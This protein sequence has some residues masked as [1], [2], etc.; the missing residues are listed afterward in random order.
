MNDQFDDDLFEDDMLED[1]AVEGYCVRCRESVEI[2]N[3]LPVWTRKGM[4]ATRGDCPICGGIVFRMGKTPAH[5]TSSRPNAVQVGSNKRKQPK[6]PQDTVYVNFAVDDELIAEQIADDL[7][8]VGIAAWLHEHNPNDQISWAGGVH[9]ALKECAR[10]VLVLSAAALDAP[11]VTESWKF[12]KEKRKPIV[13]AQVVTADPPD[14]I[15]RSPRFDFAGDYKTAFRQMVQA[16]S[17]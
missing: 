14:M 12:F 6:L 13:I 5:N 17:Q 10:M 4:P 8:K 16:L 1:E 2:E 7:R 9:P 11:S 15:R 3:P